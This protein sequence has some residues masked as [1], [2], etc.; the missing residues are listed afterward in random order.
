MPCEDLLLPFSTNSA[1]V[2]IQQCFPTS[3][4]PIPPKG[5]N[6]LKN[7][8]LQNS[9]KCI[10][11][12]FIYQLHIFHQLISIVFLQHCT[13][14]LNLRT[15]LFLGLFLRTMCMRVFYMRVFSVMADGHYRRCTL[16][17]SQQFP[18]EKSHLVY[19]LAPFKHQ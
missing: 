3:G 15:T 17:Q 8:L 19:S 5:F 18:V 10:Y 1:L 11:V 4:F 12:N 14:T 2:A 7:I 9:V 6:A 13:S 16:R